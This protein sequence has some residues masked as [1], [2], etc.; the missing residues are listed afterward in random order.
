LRHGAQSGSRSIPP[1]SGAPVPHCEQV[2]GRPSGRVV[3]E[4]AAAT[5]VLEV[6]MEVTR[7]HVLHILRRANPRD[8]ADKAEDELPTRLDLDDALNWAQRHGATHDEIISQPGG[9]P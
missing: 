4:A 3:T 7:E 8:L 5:R 2:R 1:F 6:E 9:S